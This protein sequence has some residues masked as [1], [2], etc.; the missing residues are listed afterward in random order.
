MLHMRSRI[1]KGEDGWFKNGKFYAISSGIENE[2]EIYS[3]AQLEAQQELSKAV[4]TSTSAEGDLRAPESSDTSTAPKVV[5]RDNIVL[6]IS[7]LKQQQHKR[8]SIE[9]S[10]SPKTASKSVVVDKA[11]EAITPITTIKVNNCEIINSRPHSVTAAIF[12]HPT[13]LTP[14]KKK[15]EV[16]VPTIKKVEKQI[17]RPLQQGNPTSVTSTIFALRTKD[18]NPGYLMFS[19]DTDSGLTSEYHRAF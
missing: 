7:D 12:G 4:E 13:I 6:G 5:K 17:F 2:N 11:K 14:Q 8:A 10:K 3:C 15:I 16:K 19:E 1:G 18:M 9:R